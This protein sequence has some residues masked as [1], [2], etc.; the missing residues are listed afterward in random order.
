MQVGKIGRKMDRRKHAAYV[1]G[2]ENAPSQLSIMLYYSRSTLEKLI[3][4]FVISAV[5]SLEWLLIS[6]LQEDHTG[7]QPVT[8]LYSFE[9]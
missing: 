6:E 3:N 2:G 9:G 4:I 7:G 1:R 5:C 8:Y